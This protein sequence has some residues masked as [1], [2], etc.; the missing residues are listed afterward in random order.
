VTYSYGPSPTKCSRPAVRE[1]K[2]RLLAANSASNR[3]PRAAPPGPAAAAAAPA[4]PLLRCAW[5]PA[6][7]L[8]VQRRFDG[9]FRCAVAVGH[10]A[11]DD[12]APGSARRRSAVDAGGP[13]GGDMR[14]CARN[15]TTAPR[16][17]PPPHWAFCSSR[18][19]NMTD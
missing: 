12:V 6:R 10:V 5:P 18:S 16:I 19:E 15:R 3:I 7:S 4:L 1:L 17:G 9:V 13:D 11:Y 2:G 14:P 8:P